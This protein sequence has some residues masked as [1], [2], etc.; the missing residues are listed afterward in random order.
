MVLRASFGRQKCP[1]VFTAYRWLFFLAPPRRFPFIQFILQQRS[2]SEP[3]CLPPLPVALAKMHSVPWKKGTSLPSI[4]LLRLFD[5]MISAS[6]KAGR[7]RILTKS[8]IYL[9]MH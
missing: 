7:E 1:F 2:E 5:S 8:R 4:C 6:S 3:R 9:N